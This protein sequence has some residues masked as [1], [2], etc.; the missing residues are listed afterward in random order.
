MHKKYGSRLI[1]DALSFLGLCSSYKEALRFEASI[2]NDPTSHTCQPET[3]VQYIFDNADHNT[4][5]IDGKNT[6]HQMGCIK[7]ATPAYSVTSKTTISRLKK[8][9]T[10]AVLGKF[11][12]TKLMEFQRNNSEGLKAVKIEDIFDDSNHSVEFSMEDFI[13]LYSKYS[14]EKSAGWNGFMEKVFTSTS[15]EI[16]K[17]SPTT[18]HQ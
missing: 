15:Y 3:Y 6:F 11:G 14:N 9:P 5:T 12:Y 16:S 18:F 2:I 7:A 8:T 17:I 10:S 4:C 1:I 13:W